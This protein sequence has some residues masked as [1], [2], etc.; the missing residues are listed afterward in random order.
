MPVSNYAFA[1]TAVALAGTRYMN[2]LNEIHK[3][4]S[5]TGETDFNTVLAVTYLR[6]LY[7]MSVLCA[8]ANGSKDM[9]T[10]IAEIDAKVMEYESGAYERD[11]DEP[12]EDIREP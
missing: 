5:E 6:G 10:S 7:D 9:Q 12:A 4:V 2:K 1:A 3:R 8:R 11:G